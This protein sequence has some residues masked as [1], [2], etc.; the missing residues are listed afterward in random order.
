MSPLASFSELLR[1]KSLSYGFEGDPQMI[2]STWISVYRYLCCIGMHS[3]RWILMVGYDNVTTRLI[4]TPHS[5]RLRS[6]LASHSFISIRG[7]TMM[8]AKS[9]RLMLQ[10]EYSYLSLHHKP[11]PGVQ[12]PESS[13]WV[14]IGKLSQLATAP[15]PHSTWPVWVID[16]RGGNSAPA[17]SAISYQLQI[18]PKTCPLCIETKHYHF[19]AF[20]K[21]S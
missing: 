11:G 9:G 18:K 1:H 20:D 19:W 3:A 16:H 17:S 12:G 13:V 4:I 7:S 10:H 2:L 15:A 8:P 21:K 14:N 5:H 6:E